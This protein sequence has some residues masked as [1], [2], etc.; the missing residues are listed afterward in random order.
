MIHIVLYAANWFIELIN[1][2]STQQEEDI[3]VKRMVRLQ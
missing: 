1:R 3:K 2:F